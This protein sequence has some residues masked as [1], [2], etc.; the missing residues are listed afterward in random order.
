MNSDPFHK[1]VVDEGQSNCLSTRTLAEVSSDRMRPPPRYGEEVEPLPAK[2]DRFR[3]LDRLGQGAFGV[4][5]LA[6]DPVL[7]REIALKTPQRRGGWSAERLQ[8]FLQEART[9]ARLKNPHVVTVYE[10]GTCDEADV[11]IAMEWIAGESLDKRLRRGKLSVEEAVRVCDHIAIAVQQAHKLGLV[12]RDLK[13]SNVLIDRDGN[14][15]VCDFGLALF[16]NQQ[17]HYRGEVSGTLPYMSPEQVRGEAH[18]LDGRTDVWSMGV[19]L[20]ECLSG[21]R[22][23]QA[24]ERLALEE[25]ILTRDPKPLRQIDETLPKPLDEL[26]QRC[27]D[28]EPRNRLRSAVDFRE[29]LKAQ[30]RT[31][32]RP[33]KRLKFVLAIG[34][35][36]L[37]SVAAI[38]AAAWSRFSAGV[39]PAPMALGS[40]DLLARQPEPFHFNATNPNENFFYSPAMRRLVIVSPYWTLF[41]CGEQPPAMKLDISALRGDPPGTAGFF[42]GLHQERNDQGH[43]TWKCL[44]VVVDPDRRREGETIVRLYRFHGYVGSNSIS[45]DNY[46]QTRLQ[47]D[48]AAPLRLEAEIVDGKL[49]GVR[50]N[51]APIALPISPLAK[52]DWRSFAGGKCGLVSN[53]RQI[54]FTRAFLTEEN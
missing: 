46:G 53:E 6:H 49:L 50:I 23:F 15:H 2:I 32:T 48:L 52:V 18:L 29:A 40:R 21:K 3:I 25:S 16:E 19:I 44:L 34:A 47:I 45:T 51:D 31:A 35:L 8:S 22:P 26:C 4:V 14:A 24:S 33:R 37:A 54:S 12:H 41:E 17:A 10:A 39:M 11:Y 28:R 20:Y 5:Y 27:L 38:S 9:A 30:A 7:D 42:W 1:D 36:L 43:N 13:P